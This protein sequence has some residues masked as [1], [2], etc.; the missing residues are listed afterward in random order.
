MDPV[1]HALSGIALKN[2]G[3][4][5]KG[6][7]GVALFASIAP[8]LDYIT[9]FWGTDVFL[10][11]HRGITHSVFAL[12]AVSI[13]IGLILGLKKGFFY[14]F[15]LSALSYGLHLFL[16]LT[17]Q[18][19]TRVLSP[20]DWRPFSLDITFIIDPYILAGLLISAVLCLRNK[21]KAAR[22]AAFTMALLAVY[23]GGRYYLH[24]KA[25]DFLGANM[26]DYTCK[27]VPLPND[28]TR[29][30]FVARSKDDIKVGFSDLFTK[31]LCV[32]ESYPPTPED[33]AI[34]KSKE[35][36]AVKNFLYF[37]KYPYADVKR[38]DGMTEVRWR[39]LSFSFIPGEHFVAR[40]VT[41]DTGRVVSSGFEF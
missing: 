25:R 23:M 32:Q 40:V 1:T 36:R 9:R 20:L 30:W 15:F 2:L 3:F 14:Y 29:W 16:D 41:D 35:T 37:A 13:A 22:F 5:R 31:R 8:D 19:G 12:L 39:E 34:E 11:Y 26:R 28:F 18:Y 27:V 33:P 24:G 17:N 4:R 7:L 21:K 10:R 38:H 6:A